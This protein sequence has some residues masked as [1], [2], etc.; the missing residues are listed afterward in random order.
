[1][2]ALV[3]RY[4]VVIFDMYGCGELSAQ[5]R[6]QDWTAESR[7]DDL[8]SVADAVD[9]SAFHVVG[10]SDGGTIALLAGLRAPRR[11]KSVTICN[12]THVGSSI[13]SIN[14]WEAM[15]DEVGVK[16]WSDGTTMNQRFFPDALSPEMRNWYSRQQAAQSK[17]WISRISNALLAVD[18]A[19]EVRAS[20]CP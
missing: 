3:S 4:W 13:Q 1:M 7:V 9:A 6:P 15:L 17:E 12:A 2:P 10:E 16:G 18:I 19:D 14:V 20:Q 5:G 8:L 11:V